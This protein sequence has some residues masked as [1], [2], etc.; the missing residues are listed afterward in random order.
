MA[1]QTRARRFASDTATWPRE[2]PD[3]AGPLASTTF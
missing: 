2:A 1:G 3:F